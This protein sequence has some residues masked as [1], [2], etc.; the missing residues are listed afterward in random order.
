MVTVSPTGI[1][2]EDSDRAVHSAPS[3]FTAPVAVKSSISSVTRA[4]RP[5]S[6]SALVAVRLGEKYFRARGRTRA[7]VT[8]ETTRKIT[9]WSHTLSVKKVE[10]RAARAPAANQMETSPTVSASAAPKRTSSTNH[11]ALGSQGMPISSFL[12]FSIS[13]PGEKGKRKADKIPSASPGKRSVPA[14]RFRR[15]TMAIEK[16][17]INIV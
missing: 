1:G 12:K 10:S 6:R 9:A 16:K 13:Y 17:E 11:T 3:I 14:R 15:G 7:S 4:F 5:M 2:A 8:A